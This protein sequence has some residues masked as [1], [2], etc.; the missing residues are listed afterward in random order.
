MADA[1]KTKNASSSGFTSVFVQMS[2][3]LSDAKD[4]ELKHPA[5]SFWFNCLVGFFLVLNAILIGVETDGPVRSVDLIDRIGYFSG[6]TLFA[7]FFLAEML[8]RQHQLSWDYFLDPWNFFDYGL[9]VLT[10]TDLMSSLGGN[11]NAVLKLACSLRILRLL[12]VA[13]VIKGLVVVNSLWALMQGMLE[14]LKTLFWIAVVFSGITYCLAVA[15]TTLVALDPETQEMW[16]EYRTYCGSVLRSFWTLVQ[17]ITLDSWAEDIARPIS[18]TVPSALIVIFL[19]IIICNF[20]LLNLIIGTV[21]QRVLVMTEEKRNATTE[22]LKDVENLVLEDIETD[23]RIADTSGDGELDQEEFLELLKTPS[24]LTKLNLLRIRF[25]EAESMF[26]LID[27]DGS[28]TINDDEFKN[29]LAQLKGEAQ[30]TALVNLI[31]QAQKNSAD[32]ARYVEQL[33]RLNERVKTLQERVESVGAVCTEEL[34]NR[35]TASVRT[36]QVWQRAHERVELLEQFERDRL[37]SFPAKDFG[38]G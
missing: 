17:V 23:F 30:G 20:G 1:S 10:L 8:I 18:L 38:R 28:G 34:R 26:E 27:A 29:G 9:V 22:A 6:E 3:E 25:D 16:P 24:F 31:N 12:R 13:R 19:A 32:C 11:R 14:S 4:R 36:E 35:N 7:I 15:L 21:V 2:A 33:A 37:L 5:G